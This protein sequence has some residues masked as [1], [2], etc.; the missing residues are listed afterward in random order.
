MGLLCNASIFALMVLPL[1]L[2]SKGHHVEFRRLIAL[3]AIIASCMISESTLLGSLAGV[4]PLQ[5][6]VTVVVVPVLDTLLM[7]F[8]LNDP[9]ARKVLRIHD[10]GDDAAAVLT[11]L[12]T[13]VDLLL[14]RWFRWY[15]F[16]SGLGFDAENLVSAVEAFVDLNARLLSSRR[17]NGWS[18]NS[19]KSNSKRRAWIDVAIVRVIMTAVG[20]ASRSTLIGNVLFTAALVLMQLLLPPLPENGSREE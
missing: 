3:A 12:W 1:F 7:D 20:V 18:H 10:A 17:I 2:L 6:I 16:I 5:H 13:A 4:P 19:V 9:K 15:H 8:V 14:Y 11:A